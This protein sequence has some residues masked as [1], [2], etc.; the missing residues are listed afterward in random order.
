MRWQG[1]PVEDNVWITEDDLV[2]LPPDL[3][4]PLPDTLANLT[5]S[6]SSDPGRI[7]GVRTFLA[8][9]C[10]SGPLLIFALLFKLSG[11]FFSFRDPICEAL[12]PCEP[13][14]F[15]EHV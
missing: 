5:E 12:L 11:G 7:G 15:Y 10:L 13:S 9:T 3:L 14:Y 1:R 6:S 8:R 2:R 4:E